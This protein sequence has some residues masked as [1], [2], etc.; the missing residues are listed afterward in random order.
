MEILGNS[1]DF[2]LESEFLV[3]FHLI[4]L[5]SEFNW[6][7]LKQKVLKFFSYWSVRVKLLLYERFHADINFVSLVYLSYW[8]L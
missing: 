4:S 6:Y 5:K 1:V 3:K 7:D 8:V 2:Y